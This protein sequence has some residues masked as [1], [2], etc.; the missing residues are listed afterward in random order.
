MESFRVSAMSD[1]VSH[2]ITPM[3]RRGVLVKPN[4]TLFL[5]MSK[6]AARRLTSENREHYNTKVARKINQ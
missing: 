5:N 1:R 4:M 3:K 2:P 6:A